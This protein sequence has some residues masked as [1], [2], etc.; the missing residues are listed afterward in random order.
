MA[1]NESARAAGC[2]I[3]QRVRQRRQQLGLTQAAVAGPFTAAYISALERGLLI[4]S[5][6]AM[7][8]LSVALK[9]RPTYLLWGL[10]TEVPHD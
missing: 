4:P 3:G 7:L 2:Y 6:R 5:L 8:H 1:R 10:T 9:V